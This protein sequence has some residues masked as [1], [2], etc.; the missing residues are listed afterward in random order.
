MLRAVRAKAVEAEPANE[1]RV[2]VLVAADSNGKA[3]MVWRGVL[4]RPEGRIR[5]QH[6]S[7][8]LRTLC[9]ETVGPEAANESRVGLLMAADSGGGASTMSGGVLERLQRRCGRQEA[10]EHDCTRHADTLVA[11]IEVRDAVLTQRDEWDA[12][13]ISQ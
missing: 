1:R 5:L 8:V 12:A 3:R 9:A 13:E 7:D 6:V 2:E 11:Q 4:E 10:A